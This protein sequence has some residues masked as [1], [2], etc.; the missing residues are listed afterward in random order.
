M[1][2][3]VLHDRGM[4]PSMSMQEFLELQADDITSLDKV[5]AS[6]SLIEVAV[7]VL[8]A[9]HGWDQIVQWLAECA[10]NDKCPTRGKLA[11]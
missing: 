2:Y 5:S 4:I 10:E 1:P 9:D 11:C 3:N 6:I 8:A 7:K